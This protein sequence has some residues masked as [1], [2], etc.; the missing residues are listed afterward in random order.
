MGALSGDSAVASVPAVTGKNSAGGISVYGETTGDGAGA[1]VHGKST[2]YGVHG[3]S[4]GAT[5]VY[6]EG[7]WNGVQ[8][9]TADSSA[10]GVM[11]YNTGGGSGVWGNSLGGTGVAG[12]GGVGVSGS[13]DPGVQGTSPGGTGVYGQGGFNG[14]QGVTANSLLVA[15]GVRIAARVTGSE[16]R[17]RSALVS[18]ARV[19][20]TV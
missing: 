17:A 10:S 12:T 2:H 3:E 18:T 16:A 14:V 9:V 8:G 4:T 15:S 13:G 11:G 6:G 20:L 5:G 7:A 19:V 1:G